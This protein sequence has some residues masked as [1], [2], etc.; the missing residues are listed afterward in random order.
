MPALA[1]VPSPAL[2]DETSYVAL[3]DSYS[4]GLGTRT[5]LD[6]GTACARSE[7]AHPALLAAAA[8]L[9]LDFQACAGATVAVVSSTQL[10]ALT[11]ETDYVTVSVGGNDAGFATVMTVCA[12]PRWLGNCRAAVRSART[13]IREVLPGALAA[14]YTE[15]RERAPGATVVAVGYPR[16]FGGE[17]CNAGTWF[18]PTELERLNATTDLL[19][20]GTAAAAAA[21]G[22]GFA[23]PTQRFTG[24]GVCDER[25]WVNGLAR[26]VLESYHPNGRGQ[27]RGYLPLVSR[28]LTGERVTVADLA[29]RRR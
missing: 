28:V 12:L 21:A 22:F 2:A 24:H 19:N 6:D 16:V 25:E 15:L 26:P 13:T 20:A 17:D 23:D 29:P 10:D 7:R 9:T 11:T 5:Y 3:G 18:S 27:A 4:S 14:L 8:G 1:L